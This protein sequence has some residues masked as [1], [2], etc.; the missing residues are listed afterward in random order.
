MKNI[1]IVLISLNFLNCFGDN[2]SPIY[3]LVKIQSSKGDEIFLKSKNWGLTYDH[4]LTFISTSS[5][6]KWEEHDS[7]KELVYKGLEPFIYEYKKDTLFIFCRLKSAIPAEFKSE[8]KIIQKEVENPE[9]IELY[10]KATNNIGN[11]KKM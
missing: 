6:Q 8:I 2:Y 9:Y 4:Q 1:F 5:I 11:L 10:Q 3:K 7:T